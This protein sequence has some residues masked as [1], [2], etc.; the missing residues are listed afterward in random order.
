MPE[1]VFIHKKKLEMFLFKTA[2]SESW[3]VWKVIEQEWAKYC[4]REMF[5]VSEC[6][7]FVVKIIL[8]FHKFCSV[9]FH[10]YYYFRTWY[11]FISRENLNAGE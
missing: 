3:T 4:K 7:A 5:L 8:I 2:I 9:G 11:S 1:F 6:Y 10:F